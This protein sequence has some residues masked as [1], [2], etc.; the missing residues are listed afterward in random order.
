MRKGT[1]HSPEARLKIRLE[2]LRKSMPADVFAEFLAADG[3]LKWCPAC[4]RLLLVSEFHK[5]K[6]AYDGL[7]DRCK[8]CNS[9]VSNQWHRDKAQ[10]SDYRERKNQRAKEWRATNQG[11]KL[12]RAYKDANLRQNYGITIEQFE[13]MLAAQGGRCAICRKPFRRSFDTHVDHDHATGRVRGILCSACNN[14]L[15]RFRDDPAVLR[16]AARY[17]E[18]DRMRGDAPGN[19]EQGTLWAEGPAA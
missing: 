7:Y 12:T 2:R 8:A 5:N 13:T 15:G 16:H 11:E 18:R 6:R 19:D 14:G 1:H 9:V 4:Q 3:A 10:D 17:L